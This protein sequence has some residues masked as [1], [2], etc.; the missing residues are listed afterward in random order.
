MMSTARGDRLC[1]WMCVSLKPGMS[2]R[3]CRSTCD[4]AE[5]FFTISSPPTARIL[6]SFTTT[7]ER[8]EKLSSTVRTLPLCRIMSA[9]SGFEHPCSKA[10]AMSAATAAVRYF[11]MAEISLE[12]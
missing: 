8:I 5:Y 11:C 1:T 10:V 7:A 2:T 4:C 9:G 12:E 6:P 3:P